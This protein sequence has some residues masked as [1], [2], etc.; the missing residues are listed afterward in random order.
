M[1]VGINAGLASSYD[2]EGGNADFSHYEE[3]NGIRTDN[4]IVTAKTILGPG[5]IYRFW[6][7]HMT[8]KRNFILRMY[9]DGEEAPRIDTNSVNLLG[10]TFGHF[11]S[12]LVTTCAGGQVCYEPIPFRTSV[13]I[14][15]EN[16][17]LPNY[18]SWDSNRHYYQYSY[19]KFSTDTV[20]E[21][22]TET[23][24]TQQQIDR[25]SVVSLFENAGE[26]PAG[27]S[28]TAIDI[29]LPTTVIEPNSG[30]DLADLTGPGVIRRLHIGMAQADDA[31]L[32]GLRLQVYYDDSVEAAI[33][34]PVGSFFGA[35]NER[36]LYKS[37][38]TIRYSQRPDAGIMSADCSISSS[39]RI[40]SICWKAMMLLPL[41][42]T[43]FFTARGWKMLITAATTTTGLA[44]SR[45]NPRG[46]ILTRQSGR[47]T[48]SFVW[49]PAKAI[50]IV[51]R[52]NIAGEL[53]T[54]CRF[55][56]L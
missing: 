45:M 37:K 23:L 38:S 43:A 2:R 6:M 39:P 7:P 27:G 31:E 49:I 30:I 35:G 33:D 24:T 16:K 20:L 25:A 53:R 13:R 3:P 36:A 28:A 42:A 54:V 14:E 55:R 4:E 41:T 19:M 46:R 50:S 44:F 47:F 8:A 9:F 26:H 48:E 56:G 12:P 40:V 5:I 15:T 32:D 18:P 1:R 22:Y 52:T 11:S 17:T 34:V 51:G 29:D 10:G 21:S